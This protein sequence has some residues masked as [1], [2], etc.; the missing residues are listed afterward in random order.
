MPEYPPRRAKGARP[1]LAPA[2]TQVLLHT[3][4]CAGLQAQSPGSVSPTPF[5]RRATTAT[6]V[7]APTRQLLELEIRRRT[8]RMTSRPCPQS[9]TLRFVPLCRFQSEARLCTR[10]WKVLPGDAL[11]YQS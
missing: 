4:R 2:Q 11:P 7:V 1:F 10:T 5:G 6:S 3:R 9:V 8:T